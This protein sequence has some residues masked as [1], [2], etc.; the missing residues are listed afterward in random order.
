MNYDAA[1]FELGQADFAAVGFV[2]HIEKLRE[3]VLVRGC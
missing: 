1:T 3:I 2:E